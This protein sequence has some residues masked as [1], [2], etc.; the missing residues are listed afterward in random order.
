M[1]PRPGLDVV[2]GLAGGGGDILV[3]ISQLLLDK[4]PGVDRLSLALGLQLLEQVLVGQ[5]FH[6]TQTQ[7][8][9]SPP[10]R[11]S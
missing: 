9:H 10:P 8:G 3:S 11:P 2:L 5:L 1:E 7:N 4:G 6:Q